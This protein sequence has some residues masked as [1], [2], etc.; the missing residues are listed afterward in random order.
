MK[1]YYGRPDLNTVFAWS[2][3][4][5]EEYSANPSDYWNRKA[6][7]PL[8]D[9]EGGEMVLVVRVSQILDVD[10]LADL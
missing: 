5:R 4:T 9:G 3:G 8:L 1:A 7:E 6:D 10:M 2:P